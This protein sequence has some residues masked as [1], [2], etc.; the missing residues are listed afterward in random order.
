MTRNERF[1]ARM[2]SMDQFAS[3]F[4]D[5][6]KIATFSDKGAGV[7]RLI[8][9][10]DHTEPPEKP[11][12]LYTRRLEAAVKRL[13]RAN[14]GYLVPTLRLIAKNHGNRQESIWVIKKRNRASWKV[15]EWLYYSHRKKLLNFFLAQ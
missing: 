4:G 6:S 2:L 13:T 12:T 5:S 11:T 1:N 3:K 9:A 15:A 10:I 14:L 8:D 7:E